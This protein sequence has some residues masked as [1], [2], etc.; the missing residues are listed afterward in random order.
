MATT[1]A[2]LTLSSADLTGDA[3]AVS[4]TSPLHKAGVNVGLDQT[5]G[6]AKKVYAAAQSNATL[7][8]AGDYDDNT[9][10][11][12]DIKNPMP[13]VTSAETD[14]YI[15]LTLGASNITLG[16]LYGGQWCFLPYEGEQDIDITTSATN[17]EVEF[18]VVYQTA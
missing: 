5:S 9:A 2:T 8:S 14:D 15:T 3:I 4:V 12:V 11:W 18:M 7:I 17:M 6:L 10:N 13:P 1:T 16:R